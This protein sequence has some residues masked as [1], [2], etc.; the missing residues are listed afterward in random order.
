MTVMTAAPTFTS[1]R[2]VLAGETFRAMEE[3]NRSFLAEHHRVLAYYRRR[4]VDD[5]LHAWSRRWEYPFVFDAL[6]AQVD[7]PATILDAGAGATFFPFFVADHISDSVVHAV[8]N[9][10]RLREV[11][12]SAAHPA[13]R[14]ETEDIC[15]M[16][17]P[18]GHFDAG[19]SVSVLEHIPNR[20]GVA[21]EMAR[22][23]KPGAPL[24]MTIDIS[25][26]GR[27]E[28]KLEEAEDLLSE[29]ERGFEPVGDSVT[30]RQAVADPDLLVTTKMDPAELPWS[31]SIPARVYRM[32]KY[33]KSPIRRST[34]ALTHY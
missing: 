11:Y 22:V 8:D 23:L 34:P 10:S 18:T 13:V 3:H 29:L 5:P 24:V 12:D 1:L 7:N 6:R 2:G 16:S 21:D 19:Y 20:S 15:A 32:F 31:R 9:D 14:F 33:H 30:L 4:W 17:F 27:D 28:I 25:L 26:D